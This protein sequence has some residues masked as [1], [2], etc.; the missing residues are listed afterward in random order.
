M[1]SSVTK[2]Q[3]VLD[4][5]DDADE[6]VSRSFAYKIWWKNP[7]D[8]LVFSFERDNS[9]L[10]SFSHVVYAKK[11][12]TPTSLDHEWTKIITQSDWIDGGA[13]CLLPKNFCSKPCLMFFA[14]HVTFSKNYLLVL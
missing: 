12:S 14:V 11:D 7:A 5:P 9:T 10:D 3:I 1:S 2:R 13:S 6:Y 4:F 8:N